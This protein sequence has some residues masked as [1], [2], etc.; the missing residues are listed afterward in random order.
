MLLLLIGL[1][2]LA[3]RPDALALGAFP[4]PARVIPG[5]PATELIAGARDSVLARPVFAVTRRPVATAAVASIALPSSDRISGIIVASDGLGGQQGVAVMQPKDGGKP[6]TLH[7]GDRFK[8]RLITGIDAAG[9]TLAG[10]V[11]VRPQF[12]G[13]E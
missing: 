7:V 9:I 10:G 1:E 2:T 8:G 6:I 11:V 4:I 12:G 5:L 3:R 13:L